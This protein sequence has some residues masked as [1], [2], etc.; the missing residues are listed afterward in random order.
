MRLGKGRRDRVVLLTE[1]VAQWLTRYVTVARPELA[2]GKL[3]G[4]GGKCDDD[5]K[6]SSNTKLSQLP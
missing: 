3:W 6:Y 5:P 1:T 4:K 2:A